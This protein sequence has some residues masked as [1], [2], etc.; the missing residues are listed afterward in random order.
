M[1]RRRRRRRP[2]DVDPVEPDRGDDAATRR[3]RLP[4]RAP[5]PTR[6]RCG[7]GSSPRPSGCRSSLTPPELAPTPD[8][9]READGAS[10]FTPPESSPPPRC[11]RPRT[12]LLRL[13]RRPAGPG[14]RPGPR[15]PDRRRRTCPAA[16]TRWRRRTS[17]PA[18]VQIVTSGRV[19]DVLVGP[20][21]TG[22]TTTMA[23]VRAMWEAEH[24]PGTVVGLAPSAMAAQVLAADLG[25]VTDNT[26]QWLAQQD[27]QDRR[28]R[29]DPPCSTERDRPRAD[30]P[31]RIDG[32]RAALDRLRGRVRPVAAA[33]RAAADRRRGR[34][35]RHLH[36]GP[37]GP[38]GRRRR[39]E[40]AAGRRPLPAVRGRDRRRVRPALRPPP[41]PAHADPGPP[42]HRPRRHPPHLGRAR[43]RPA[44]RRRPHRPRRLRRPRPDPLRRPGP[45]DRRRLHRLV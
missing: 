25:I 11:W 30:D 17:G 13:G 1:R 27:Q 4:V 8:A 22:K 7:T 10:P 36:P 33:A 5:P 12:T 2:V 20:A 24:G 3:P 38:A 34:H 31:A 16:T 45:D 26:A 42:V 6:S 41:G 29:S 35:D 32:L 15:R 9:L 37:P 44:P 23:G 40:A 39:R 18:A 19:V 43:R 28:E 14:R 21:G